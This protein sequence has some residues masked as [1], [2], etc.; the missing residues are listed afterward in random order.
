M[1]W[2][3]GE[4]RSAL[5]AALSLGDPVG[6]AALYL[7]DARLLTPGAELVEGRREIEA[8]WRTGIAL[9]VSRIE[10]ELLELRRPSSLAVEIG[11]YALS[12]SPIGGDKLVDRG[13]Y[14]VLHGQ[15]VDGSWR[16]AVDV[17]TPNGLGTSGQIRKEKPC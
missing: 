14:V 4:T 12:V 13:K 7:D 9:G 6:A 17:F 11:R 10:L 2:A 16:R 15:H 5:A 8:Y 1:E 3:I